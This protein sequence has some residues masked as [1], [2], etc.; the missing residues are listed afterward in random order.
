MSKAIK[1]IQAPETFAEVVEQRRV[2]DIAE[3]FKSGKVKPRLEEWHSLYRLKFD[4]RQM[5]VCWQFIGTLHA[6]IVARDCDEDGSI[7]LLIMGVGRNGDEFCFRCNERDFKTC[8]RKFKGRL[9]E[10]AGACSFVMPGRFAQLVRA[11]EQLSE[12]DI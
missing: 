11:I 8:S 4:E 12:A 3:F 1:E 2:D 10:A 6:R 5:A 9:H 7:S